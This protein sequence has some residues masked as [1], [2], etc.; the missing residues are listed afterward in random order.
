M[1]VPAN[2]TASCDSAPRRAPPVMN[3][4][5]RWTAE[6]AAVEARLGWG[7]RAT[8]RQA[9]LA[10]PLVAV[11]R[12]RGSSGPERR[13][14]DGCLGCHVSIAKPGFE[15]YPAPFRTH[16]KL[17]SYV[18]AAVAASTLA[19]HLRGVSPGRRSRDD[20]RGGSPFDAPRSDTG[21]SVRTIPAGSTRRLRRDAARAPCRSRLRGVPRRRALSTWRTGAERRHDHA[22]A[23]RLLRLPRHA[24]H[25]ADAEARPGPAA[26]RCEAHARL[27]ARMARESARDQA[28]DLDA[29]ASGA[30]TA[31]PGR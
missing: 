11:M 28:S 6:A 26:H 24:R 21:G 30:G 17:A 31:V 1:R 23:R 10:S 13:E 22:A 4:V 12:P 5:R 18:G 15:Q 19:R 16:S 7:D 20:V 29:R 25:V 3:S 14:G 2:A 8:V 27:G 9:L